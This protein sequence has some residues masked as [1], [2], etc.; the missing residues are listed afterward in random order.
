MNWNRKYKRKNRILRKWGR[1]VVVWI[2]SVW[3]VWKRVCLLGSLIYNLKFLRELAWFVSIINKWVGN[4]IVIVVGI[5]YEEKNRREKE[6]Y[7]IFFLRGY[8][9][10]E[11]KGLYINNCNI[12]NYVIIVVIKVI[13]LFG[14]NIGWCGFITIWL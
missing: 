8:S 13:V 1:V 6:E 3:R 10:L 4:V 7:I 2:W 11:E 14:L 12:R 9:L 5:I